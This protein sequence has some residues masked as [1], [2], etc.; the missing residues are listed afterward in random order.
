MSLFNSNYF[1]DTGPPKPIVK[2]RR[3]GIQGGRSQKRRLDWNK[4][5]KEA[6]TLVELENI[7]LEMPEDVRQR[8][9]TYRQE[10]KRLNNARRSA[11]A[12]AAAQAEAKTRASD[13]FQLPIDD[14]DVFL[15]KERAYFNQSIDLNALKDT[16]MGFA[17]VF[18]NDE[19]HSFL[20]AHLSKDVIQ[21]ML[22]TYSFVFRCGIAASKYAYEDM[23]HRKGVPYDEAMIDTIISKCQELPLEHR[24]GVERQNYG[25]LYDHVI[26]KHVKDIFQSVHTV[27]LSFAE[28]L[29]NEKVKEVETRES[30]R[31]I[32]TAMKKDVHTYTK[33]VQHAPEPTGMKSASARFDA[34]GPRAHTVYDANDDLQRR[35]AVRVAFLIAQTAFGYFF[36]R[37][38][39]T[40]V[41]AGLRTDQNAV[42]PG[43]YFLA[44]VES[45]HAGESSTWLFPTNHTGQGQSAWA[46]SEDLSAL[47]N[48]TRN[49][50]TTASNAFM[51]SY[52]S[53]ERHISNMFSNFHERFSRIRENVVQMSRAARDVNNIERIG[54]E[55]ERLWRDASIYLDQMH[56]IMASVNPARLLI[57]YVTLDMIRR[58]VNT[59]GRNWGNRYVG[60]IAGAALTIISAIVHQAITQFDNRLDNLLMAASDHGSLHDLVQNNIRLTFRELFG[61]LSPFSVPGRTILFRMG[62]GMAQLTT[63]TTVINRVNQ[64]PRGIIAAIANNG[65]VQFWSG[66]NENWNKNDISF[67]N[68]VQ[69]ESD[70]TRVN[71]GLS[72]VKNQLSQLRQITLPIGEV[73]K[74]E[75]ANAIVVDR[76]GESG[77]YGVPGSTTTTVPNKAAVVSTITNIGYREININLFDRTMNLNI[78][79]YMQV[80]GST[81]VGG[82][83]ALLTLIEP[84]YS[85]GV[86]AITAGVIYGVT[87]WFDRT[88][89]NDAD[90]GDTHA[91]VLLKSAPNWALWDIVTG[92]IY[93]ESDSER[94]VARMQIDAILREEQN[95]HGD[96]IQ[97]EL[98]Q[99][100]T[101]LARKKIERIDM[102][103]QLAEALRPSEGGVANVA[104]DVL[105]TEIQPELNKLIVEETNLQNDVDNKVNSLSAERKRAAAE[106]RRLMSFPRF[107]G[108]E[109]IFDFEE[110]EKRDNGFN[111]VYVKKPLYGNGVVDSGNEVAGETKA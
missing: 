70:T 57:I 30:I 95:Q 111:I 44:S 79:W 87:S 29:Y 15:E 10:K 72:N 89:L 43:R 28:K 7:S 107:I 31:E 52:G 33:I 65:L 53:S 108:D 94:Q 82:A 101:E 64:R 61:M 104:P 25:N 34:T 85:A 58:Q 98:I 90:M 46:T 97:D 21:S 105:V 76:F 40:S 110:Y 11:D 38:Q 59:Y 93:K 56:Q 4:R 3:K 12:P 69:S 83:S 35:A 86:S 77:T 100:R 51:S 54:E 8:S 50:N 45:Y 2:K 66:D 14:V 49:V 109:F 26:V 71:G 91:F 39:V 36:P 16:M 92:Q 27:H 1:A 103:K 6:K 60:N 37:G 78:P 67:R 102:E 88:P 19:E 18:S 5:M 47:S 42:L 13:G 22:M 9:K 96:T 73:V 24:W 106:I 99:K 17:R 23:C 48:L 81:I 20:D 55:N 32:Y 62:A 75:N 63:L 74:H 41:D 68:G 84:S 80:F